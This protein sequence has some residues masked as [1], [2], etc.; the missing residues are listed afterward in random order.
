MR[1][2][3][4]ISR[5]KKIHHKYTYLQF[6][7]SSEMEKLIQRYIKAKKHKDISID[8]LLSYPH[9]RIVGWYADAQAY[10]RMNG[11]RFRIED[12]DPEDRIF[13]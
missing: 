5:I 7:N 10:F 13:F 1:I 6:Y 11:Y 4:L 2:Y 8:A 9:Q 12:A 3:V